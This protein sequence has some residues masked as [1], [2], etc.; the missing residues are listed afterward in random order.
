MSESID[1]SDESAAGASAAGSAGASAG[2]G[3][4]V[5][6]GGSG[7]GPPPEHATVMSPAAMIGNLRTIDIGP[8]SLP[9]DG[10]Q[11]IGMPAR[12]RTR[13]LGPVRARHTVVLGLGL[14]AACQSP[15][16]D[17]QLSLTVDAGSVEP[18]LPELGVLSVEVYG[19]RNTTTLCTLARRCLYPLDL[20]SPQTGAQLQEALRQVQPL[21]DV[22]ATVA[23]QIAVVGRPGGL[24]DEQGPF[25]VC[26]FADIATARDDELTVSLG[27][28]L[29]PETLPEFCPE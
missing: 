1:E 13:M 9:P 27:E 25:M 10:P 15:G 20:G 11:G 21:V 7:V 23:H 16:G 12:R 3:G 6:G 2:A 26:G 18:L 24:C 22:D 8:P 17:R 5:G 14:L 19:V 4:A 28:A 29:C